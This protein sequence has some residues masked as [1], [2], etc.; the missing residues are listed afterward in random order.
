M[1][2]AAESGLTVA[3][4]SHDGW[5]NYDT[6]HPEMEW[7]VPKY[8]KKRLNWAAKMRLVEEPYSDWAFPELVHENHEYQAW[9]T[10]Y[11]T[12]LDII[13]NWRSSHN[14][15]LNTFHIGL[16]RR[17]KIIDPKAITAQ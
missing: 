17:A 4:L 5:E 15:P 13:N 6:W 1:S 7:A 11:L 12:A 16:K 9:V 3:N 14:F 8:A 10:E 2:S